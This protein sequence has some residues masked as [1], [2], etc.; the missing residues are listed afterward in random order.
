MTVSFK[1]TLYITHYDHLILST[2]PTLGSTP[3]FVIW[4]GVFGSQNLP[5][6]HD[7][8]PLQQIYMCDPLRIY[9]HSKNIPPFSRTICNTPRIHPSLPEYLPPFSTTSPS[10]LC[11]ALGIQNL[12]L[13]P[14]YTPLFNKFIGATLS[15]SIITPRIYPAFQQLYATLP[16]SIPPSQNTYTPLFNI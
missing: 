7:M 9:P 2:P 10:I 3:F 11:D 8:P 16:E 5:L 14:Y 1:E 12:P 15:E 13:P 6:P 4:S